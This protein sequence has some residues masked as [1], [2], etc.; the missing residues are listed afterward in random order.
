MRHIVIASIHL[1]RRYI[2]PYK[3]FC[4]AYRM[5][6]GRASCSELGLR[7]VQRYGAFVGVAV[8][9]RR[10]YLCG[11]AHRRCTPPNRRPHRSQRGDCD[12]PCEAGCDIASCKPG[13]SI[14]NLFNCCDCASCDWP[15]RK[16]RNRDEEREVYLP[17]N[18]KNNDEHPQ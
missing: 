4:C 5:H 13:A 6:T 9:R 7:T 3:G 2:S 1:Y 10:L 16:K 11:V 14:G 18:R 17:P 12:L 15:D 8:L